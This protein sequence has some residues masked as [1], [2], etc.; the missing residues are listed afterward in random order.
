ME[1]KSN[2]NEERF[3]SFLNRTIILSSR[4]Y[5]KKQINIINKE[6]T[7]VDDMDYSTF[8]SD[9][10]VLNHKVSYIDDIDISLQLNSALKTLSAIE[11]AV[12]FLLFYEDFTQS[13]VAEILEIYSKTISK[14]KIRAIDKLKKFFKEDFENGK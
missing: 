9:F 13:E 7:I 2:Y 6:R 10:I 8:L 3:D 11:Q 5:F 12:I 14:I 1:S 4:T